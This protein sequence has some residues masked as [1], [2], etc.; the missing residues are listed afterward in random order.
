MTV[1][2][3]GFR[4][5]IDEDIKLNVDQ[6]VRVNA[7]LELGAVSQAVVV[8]A[9]APLIPTDTSTVGQVV[10]Q[11]MMSQLPLNER[12]FLQ[13]TLLVPGA[14][15]PSDGSQ[16]STQGGAVSVDGAREHSNNFLLSFRSG[17][18]FTVYR[19]VD[20][21]LTLQGGL[22]FS[23]RPDLIANPFKAG[24]VVENP[25]PLCQLTVSQQGRA[26]DRVRD[27][28][29]WFNTCAFASPSIPRFGT[30]GR[31]DIT[32]PPLDNLDFSFLKEFTLRNEARRIQL[33]FE[34]FNL[35]NHPNF[36]LPN[37]NFDTATLSSIQSSNAF[38][39]KPPRQIQMGLK[40][41]S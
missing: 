32:G 38:G 28:S 8:N 37:N 12:N 22:G 26:A 21:S 13:F 7:K 40:Y 33:R 24:P 18:P 25:D 39:N 6:T 19:A 11:Q 31:N 14:Q 30:A 41:V 1:E 16:N 20:Q 17:R 4:S 29:N 2:A 36:D 3:A 5:F 15:M 35:F 23:D 10:N 34:F 9:A 27:P